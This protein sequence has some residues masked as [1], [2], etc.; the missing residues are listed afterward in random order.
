MTTHRRGAPRGAAAELRRRIA[1]EAARLASEHGLH[2]LDAARRKAGERFGVR[3]L[4]DL[5]DLDE[6]ESALRER[7]RLFRPQAQA[8][9][10]ALRRR[11]ALG[12]MEALA[13][14]SP[15][16]VGAV[17]DGTADEGTPIRLHVHCD[18]PES[19]LRFLEEHGVRATSVGAAGAMRFNLEG[20]DYALDVLPLDALRQPAR[21]SDGAPLPRADA[22]ALRRLI[23]ATAQSC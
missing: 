13:V 8:L 12:A 6:V 17:L 14:F 9:A 11:A 7:Q 16:L 23:E 10:L 5:P 1:D 22:Q 18:E 21:R 3:R 2:D 4:A 20:L 15:R 19:V